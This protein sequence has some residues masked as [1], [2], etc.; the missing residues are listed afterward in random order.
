MSGIPIAEETEIIIDDAGGGGGLPPER[1]DGG[2]GGHG[3]GDGEGES[4]DHHNHGASGVPSQRQ[5]STAV[6]VGLVSI[7]MFFMALASAFIVLKI[8]SDVWRPVRLP[9][10]LW[11]NTA[12]LLASSFTLEVAK[13]KLASFDAIGFR[14]FWNLTTLLGVLFLVGQFVAWLQLFH[15]GIYISSTQSSS[16]FYIFTA[17]HGLHLLGGVAALLFVALRDFRKG[18]I[19]RATAAEVTSYYWHFMDGLWLFLLA[20]MYFGK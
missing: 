15:G 13:K 11:L 6:A 20:L 2:R 4:G 17:A 1:R 14:R 9:H 5:Y 8:V 7:L 19:S 12:I 16:F 10:I 3:G 18:K